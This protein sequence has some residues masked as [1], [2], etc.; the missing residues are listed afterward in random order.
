MGSLGSDNC[1]CKGSS[2]GARNFATVSYSASGSWASMRFLGRGIESGIELLFRMW[3]PPAWDLS[4]SRKD[5]L[6]HTHRARAGRCES[7][8]STLSWRKSMSHERHSRY[9][10]GVT[11]LPRPSSYVVYSTHFHDTL[12]V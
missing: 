3:P 10:L 9:E 5:W 2:I 12:P 8:N 1:I 11:P 7:L 6:P 4:H